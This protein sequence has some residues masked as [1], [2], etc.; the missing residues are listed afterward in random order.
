MDDN[1]VMMMTKERLSG[2]E[3]G[4]DTEELKAEQRRQGKWRNKTTVLAREKW[5]SE[6]RKDTEKE[7]EKMEVIASPGTEIRAVLHEINGG[8]LKEYMNH[9]F[10]LQWERESKTEAD[11]EDQSCRLSNYSFKGLSI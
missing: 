1:H 8:L 10:P 2:I 5:G 4:T 9:S 3:N 11:K 7:R 6:V